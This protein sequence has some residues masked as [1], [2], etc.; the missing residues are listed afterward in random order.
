VFEG[1][2]HTSYVVDYTENP[3]C[4]SHYT[5]ESIISLPERSS[6]LTLEELRQRAAK[7][8]ADP[9]A[10][11]EFS[12]DVI[13]SLICPSCDRREDVFAPV[14]ALSYEQGRCPHDGQPR[15]VETMHN[16]AA[17]GAA[18]S[19]RLDQLGLPP[20]DVFV[21]RS[22]ESEIAYLMAGDRADVLGRFAVESAD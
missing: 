21:G 4:S 9:G 14:G 11:I 18:G 2:N 1:L 20:F 12:R 6:G 19:R 5:F 3:D 10:V 8:L 17:G 13:S 15:S 7:D 22:G 16:Y